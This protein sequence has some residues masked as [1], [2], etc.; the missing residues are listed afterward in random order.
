MDRTRHFPVYDWRGNVVSTHCRAR[1]SVDSKHLL[2]S[3][4]VE[5]LTCRRCLAAPSVQDI[6]RK[7]REQEEERTA[8]RR[9]RAIEL[10]IERHREEYEALLQDEDVLDTLAG[11]ENTG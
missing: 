11:R 2:M 9:R 10:L 4:R 8:A 1:S 6:L 5:D 3:D 7:K